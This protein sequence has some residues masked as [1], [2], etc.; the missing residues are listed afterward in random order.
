MGSQHP[1]EGIRAKTK[2]RAKFNKMRK[3]R[4]RADFFLLRSAKRNVS[5][6]RKPTYRIEDISCA[7]K[8]RG[9]TERDPSLQSGRIDSV[10]KSEAELR[11]FEAW[12]RELKLSH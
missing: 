10:Q 8:A 6:R 7:P 3:I 2:P 11:I 4:P 12:G 9:V 5:R 1:H